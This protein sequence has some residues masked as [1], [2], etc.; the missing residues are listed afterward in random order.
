MPLSR[1]PAEERKGGNGKKHRAPRQE[2]Y[3]LF[4][5]ARF[6]K[7]RQRIEL[8]EMVG[9]IAT[10]RLG[11]KRQSKREFP[12]LQPEARCIVGL[13]P[14]RIADRPHGRS[15][16][17]CGSM[18]RKRYLKHGPLSEPPID[19]PVTKEPSIFITSDFSQLA[20]SNRKRSASIGSDLTTSDNL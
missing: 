17:T 19:S 7:T 14:D 13:E 18:K 9:F 20:W 5:K 11:L 8:S 16:R 6:A 2:A 15:P 10:L 3:N 1:Q 4:E 12:R